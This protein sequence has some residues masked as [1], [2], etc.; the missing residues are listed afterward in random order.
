MA[1]GGGISKSQSFYG[2]SPMPA[3]GLPAP[4]PLGAPVVPG[5][6]PG[7]APSTYNPAVGGIPSVP[8]PLK[9]IQDAITNYTT[10]LPALQALANQQTAANQAAAVKAITDLYPQFKSNT[11]Q[12]GADIADWAAGNIS[13]STV[14][15][16]TQRM[17]ERAIRSGFGPNAPATNAALLSLLGKTAEGLQQTA[18]TGQNTLL[19]GLPRTAP[20]S[21]ESF[22]LTP[23]NIFGNLY[24]AELQAALYRAAPDPASAYNLAMQNA[25]RGLTGGIGAGAGPYAGTPTTGGTSSPEILKLLQDLINRGSGTSTGSQTSAYYNQAPYV[26]TPATEDSAIY[27]S[28]ENLWD[29]LNYEGAYAG[30]YVAPPTTPTP[31]TLPPDEQYWQDFYFG[32]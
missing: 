7:T 4:V 27:G 13:Q 16:L 31:P 21:V 6:V 15:Q 17:G 11:A 3:A 20:V 30:D 28:P 29:Y 19:A 14:N 25:M 22:G 5:A 9:A 26:P 10:N 32:G 12:L 2:E 8:D 23:G 18:L 24:N 1:L